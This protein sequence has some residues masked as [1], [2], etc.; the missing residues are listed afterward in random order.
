MK[1]PTKIIHGGIDR[2]PFT[3]ASSIPIYQVSTFA[4]K[5]PDHFGE[6]EYARGDNP[7]RAALEE[8]IA[9]LEGGACGMAFASGMA[10]IDTILKTLRP[11]D[12]ITSTVELEE[13]YEDQGFKDAD[14]SADG[15]FED[16]GYPNYKWKLE[17]V[18]P[19]SNRPRSI[20][21]RSSSA[22]MTSST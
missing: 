17:V 5:D 11:G 10:A 2:D 7:T 8:N 22:G 3:G 19:T 13:K 20:T 21:Q 6:Y 18:K 9:V 12:E 16:Q 4:Q 1:Y 15:S 14:E